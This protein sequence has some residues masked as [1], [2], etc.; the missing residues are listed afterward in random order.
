MGKAALSRRPIPAHNLS[1]SRLEL[2]GGGWR[3]ER[4]SLVK[5]D[6]L[7]LSKPG[8]ADSTG[9]WP[10]SPAPVLVSYLNAGAIPDPNFSDNQLM[11]SDS[12]FQADFWY[13]N[14][15]S[16]P[17][18]FSG[19]RVWLNFDGINWKADVFLKAKNSAA[20]TAPSSA[21]ASM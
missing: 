12:F 7:A 2:A 10:P 3:V 9:W 21:A 6:G 18:A 16:A 11:V 15:F 1:D 5:A 14:E 8:F 13:R 4:D 17:P 19:K 20:S